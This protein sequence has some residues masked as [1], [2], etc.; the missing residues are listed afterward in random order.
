MFNTFKKD[1]KALS[2]MKEFCEKT[3]IKVEQKGHLRFVDL[4]YEKLLYNNK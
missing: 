2:L 3:G 1:D 4:A